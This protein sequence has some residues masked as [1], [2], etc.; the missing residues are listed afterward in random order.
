MDAKDAE[1]GVWYQHNK[2]GTV[3]CCGSRGPGYLNGFVVR[4][5]ETSVRFLRDY[6]VVTKSLIQSWD[7]EPEPPPPRP[8]AEEAA[9]KNVNGAVALADRLEAVAVKTIDEMVESSLKE[10]TDRLEAESE[11]VVENL[12]VAALQDAMDEMEVSKPRSLLFNDVNHYVHMEDAGYEDL[13]NLCLSL[14][15]TLEGGAFPKFVEGAGQPPTESTGNGSQLNSGSSPALT[16]VGLRV[17]R[18]GNVV[19]RP[20]LV[21]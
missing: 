8:I 4:D 3:L 2:Y 19:F 11:P 18:H 15:S 20:E 6:E 21:E 13:Q 9:T 16:D 12:A 1:A 10:F 5:G 14:A 17:D 7:A